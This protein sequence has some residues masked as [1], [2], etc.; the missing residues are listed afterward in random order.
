MQDRTRGD[1]VLAALALAALMWGLLTA[2]DIGQRVSAGFS[3]AGPQRVIAVEPGGPAAVAGLQPGDVIEQVN[4]IPV[5]DLRGQ[6]SLSRP[7]PGE[8]RHFII[9]RAGESLELELEYG[10]LSAERKRMAWLGLLPGFAFLLLCLR[11]W[12]KYPGQASRALALA[13][14]GCSLVFFTGP[15]LPGG[16]VAGMLSVARSGMV[17]SGFAAMLVFLLLVPH[18]SP[19]TRSRGKLMALFLPAIGLWLLVSSRALFAAGGHPL[20][21]R[22]TWVVTGLVTAFYLLAGV[23]VFLRRYIRTTPEARGP[24]GL[25]LILWGSLAGFL[26]AL[27]GFMPVLAPVPGTRYFYLSLAIA[28]LAWSLAC[29]RHIRMNAG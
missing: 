18:A 7:V 3:T 11:P 27:V 1:G 6:V 15:G 28:P 4:G 12:L 21:D 10:P 24:T 13:G 29:L 23:I 9:T 8:I 17:L 2:L 25:R 16:V 22:L 20:L 5:R 14:T 19:V 26:P